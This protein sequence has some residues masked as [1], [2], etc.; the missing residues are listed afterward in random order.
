MTQQ[1]LVGEL[2]ARLERLQAVTAG[3]GAV[4]V[5][6]MRQQVES[7]PLSRLAAALVRA[8]ALADGLCWDSLSAGDAASFDRQASVLAELRLFG[9]CA[10]LLADDRSGALTDGGCGGRPDEA[11]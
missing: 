11:G 4:Q 8:L 3:N 5:A 9:I 7:C 1:Y 6:Q 10:S 2:S